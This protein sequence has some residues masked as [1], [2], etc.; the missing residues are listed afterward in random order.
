MKL[1]PLSPP[2]PNCGEGDCIR[3]RIFSILRAGGES[4]VVLLC[5]CKICGLRRFMT[6]HGGAP[7]LRAR[8]RTLPRRAIRWLKAPFAG[9]LAPAGTQTHH[10]AGALRWQEWPPR[11][12]PDRLWL[13]NS[14]EERADVKEALAAIRS[15]MKPGG[16]LTVTSPNA[17]SF[18]AR[19][20]SGRLGLWEPQ[21]QRVLFT[22]ALLATLLKEAGFRRGRLSYSLAGM[23]MQAEA[24]AP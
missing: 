3:E 24:I 21:R 22:P 16:P 7:D 19:L 1:W 10:L 8:P 20:L 11:F 12:R 14:L 13:W 23:T 6:P 4:D 5:R 9:F 17:A 18:P 15:V 2:C